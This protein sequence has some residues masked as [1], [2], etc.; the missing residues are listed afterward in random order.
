[1]YP[2]FSPLPE[3]QLRARNSAEMIQSVCGRART[4]ITIFHLLPQ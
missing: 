4:E 2:D 1:M 3:R